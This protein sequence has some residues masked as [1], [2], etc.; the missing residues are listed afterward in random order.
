MARKGAEFSSVILV[1]EDEVLVRLNICDHLREQGFTVL[2]ASSVDEARTAFSTEVQID[3]VF[4]D[5]NMPGPRD[6]IELALWVQRHYPAVPVLLTSG[7]QLALAAAAAACPN[8][9]RLIPKPYFETDVEQVVRDVIA[10][11]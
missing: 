7:V 10:G 3:V 6:G 4:S 1:A 5:V 9:R 11:A 2:E 8:V